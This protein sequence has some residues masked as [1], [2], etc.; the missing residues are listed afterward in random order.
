MSLHM[1]MFVW[2]EKNVVIQEDAIDF[3]D[4]RAD[5]GNFISQPEKRWANWK[6]RIKGQWPYRP[7]ATRVLK[8]WS[9][10]P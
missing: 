7:A 1:V 9:D 3:E 2:T 10:M 8:Y 6:K 4:N 5:E